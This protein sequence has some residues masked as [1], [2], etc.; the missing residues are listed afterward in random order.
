MKTPFRCRDYAVLG[1]N[2]DCYRKVKR[3]LPKESSLH[4]QFR[5]SKAAWWQHRLKFRQE[6]LGADCYADACCLGIATCRW[7]R[8]AND[9]SGSELLSSGALLS[10]IE[11]KGIWQLTPGNPMTGFSAGLRRTATHLASM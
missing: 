4:A 5:D 9:D 1:P 7:R 2:C 10:Y 6:L 11:L 8:F 3:L